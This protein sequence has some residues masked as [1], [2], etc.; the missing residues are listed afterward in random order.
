M[1]GGAT[2]LGLPPGADALLHQGN[3]RSGDLLLGGGTRERAGLLYGVR[4][5][6]MLT[7]DSTWKTQSTFGLLGASALGNRD[8][9]FKLQAWHLG[10]LAGVVGDQPG[11][12][13]EGMG[14]N[15]RVE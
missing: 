15:H 4:Q 12:Q 13:A 14:R 9:V 11:L 2:D 10:E 7:M 1:A 6:H 5:A 3:D 8:P